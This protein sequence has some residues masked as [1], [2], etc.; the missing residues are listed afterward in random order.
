MQFCQQMIEHIAANIAPEALRMS[1]IDDK[2]GSL[3]D[4]G[5]L[6]S[7]GRIIPCSRPEPRWL[8]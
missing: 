1:P 6:G 4:P 7:L 2:F 5:S 3:G 8:G